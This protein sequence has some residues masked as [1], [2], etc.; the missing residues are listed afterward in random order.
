MRYRPELQGLIPDR[1]LVET[2]RPRS[3]PT[4]LDLCAGQG[5]SPF[6][7]RC[8]GLASTIYLQLYTRPARRV[9]AAF[10][11]ELGPAAFL[12]SLLTFLDLADPAGRLGPNLLDLTRLAGELQR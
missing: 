2:G 1:T 12:P 8:E 6:R 4:D 5:R 11:P 9:G 10:R 3:I 7:P